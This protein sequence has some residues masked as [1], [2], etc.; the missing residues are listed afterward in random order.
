MEEDEVVFVKL[1][2]GMLL[3]VQ[4]NSQELEYY[5]IVFPS[6]PFPFFSKVTFPFD[7]GKRVFNVKISFY[8]DCSLHSMGIFL[9]IF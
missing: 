5:A 2:W 9:R 3:Y 6:L 7:E 4:Y 8:S 1:F